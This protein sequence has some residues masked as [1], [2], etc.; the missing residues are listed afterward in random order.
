MANRLSWWRRAFASAAV[1]AAAAVA[2]GC[3]VQSPLDPHSEPARKIET[4][5]WWMLAA[6]ALVFLGALFLLVLAWR[7]RDT[8]GL[9]VLGTS[10]R[11]STGLVVAFG[12][13][14]P[15]IALSALFAVANLS[16]A[17]DTDAP[18]RGST[19][20][21][22]EV[23]GHQWFWEVR[24][25]GTAAV[26]ANEIHIPARTR[27]NVVVRSADV[28]HSFWA[29]EL[30]RKVDALPGHPNRMLLY[31]DGPGRYRGQCAELCGVDHAR[32]GLAVYAD[33]PAEFRRWLDRQA[34]PAAAPGT[35]AERVGQRVFLDSQCAGCHTIRGTEARGDIGPDLTH[36]Q[37]RDTLGALT[38]PN[39]RAKLSAWVRDPQ[40]FK[41]GNRMPVLDL[42]A[43]QHRAVVDYLES[44][45]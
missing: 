5:W 18:E 36:L 7:R 4:L 43:E 37:T 17:R 20:L 26:T 6:A 44:L 11:A 33:P 2:S 25:P 28:V 23:T 42:S 9:P 13:V 8:E 41:P 1:A 15:L 21:T 40:R 38:L 27:V 3:G 45:R 14:I 22:I 29:P 35:S 39:T 24:Y 30:N 12:I 16:V 34:R 10:E 19:K 31:A 32:M